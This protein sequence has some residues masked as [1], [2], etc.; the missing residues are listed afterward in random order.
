MKQFCVPAFISKL[1]T[2]VGDNTLRLTVDC[3][4]MTT[5]QEAELLRLKRKQGW[6]FFLNAPD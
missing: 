3:Q 6:F 5:D 1:T 4:E 2:L